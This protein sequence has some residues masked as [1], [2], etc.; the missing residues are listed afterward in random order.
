MKKVF[1]ID[2]GFNFVKKI[3]KRIKENATIVVENGVQIYL[4]DDNSVRETAWSIESD[5]DEEYGFLIVGGQ[6]RQLE[7]EAFMEK[8]LG[9]KRY[10][11]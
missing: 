6:L 3:K 5:F 7:R 2:D 10:K 4:L 11:K 8:W 9:E 1:N